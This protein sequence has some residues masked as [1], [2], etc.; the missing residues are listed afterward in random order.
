MHGTAE[1][2]INGGYQDDSRDLALGGT[3]GSRKKRSEAEPVP[4]LQ[5]CTT[6]AASIPKTRKLAERMLLRGAINQN[7][8]LEREL[9]VLALSTLVNTKISNPVL[10]LHLRGALSLAS[11]AVASAA[12]SVDLS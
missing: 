10:C 3:D 2:V 11:C 5:C 12:V 1:Q 8:L 4:T 9:H 6:T 7:T